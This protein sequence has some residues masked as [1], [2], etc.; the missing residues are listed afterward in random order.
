MVSAEPLILGEVGLSHEGLKGF[1][2]VGEVG[3]ANVVVRSG[4]ETLRCHPVERAHGFRRI[5]G[6]DGCREDR[7]KEY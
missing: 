2:A 7:V 4:V 5:E 1:F 3:G 6:G